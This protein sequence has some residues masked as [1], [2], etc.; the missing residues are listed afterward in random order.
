M[1][2]PLAGS[3]VRA[4]V[5]TGGRLKLK[6]L[7]PKFQ[8][9]RIQMMFPLKGTERRGLVS[10]EAKKRRVRPTS[11][12][13]WMMAGWGFLFLGGGRGGGTVWGVCSCLARNHPEGC[14]HPLQRMSGTW[15]AGQV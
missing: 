12:G 6:S 9:R 2:A 5:L 8:S 13:G 10:L 7:R 11:T 14:T 3:E 1:G 4:A 15:R